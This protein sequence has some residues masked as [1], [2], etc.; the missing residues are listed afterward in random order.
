M[1]LN[2]LFFKI[3]ALLTFSIFL[4]ENSFSAGTNGKIN[5]PMIVII[6]PG[7]G[8]K[9]PG[10]VNKGI[11]EKD[12]VLG[13]GLKLG[14]YINETYPDVKVIYTRSTDVFVPLIE[15]SRIANKNKADLFISLHANYCGTPSLR[16]TE[17]FVLGLHRSKENLDIAKKENSVILMEENYSTTYEGFDP[18]SSESYI[19]F[20]L[21]QDNYLDQSLSFADDIQRQF[22]MRVDGSNRGVKQAGFLVLRQSSMPSVLVETGFISNLAEAKQLM[23]DDGQRTIALSILEAFKKFKTRNSGSGASSRALAAETSKPDTSVNKALA[24][25]EEAKKEP[26]VSKSEDTKPATEPEKQALKVEEKQEPEV[27]KEISQPEPV[28]EKSKQIETPTNAEPSNINQ[29]ATGTDIY[30][31]VQIGANTTPVEPVSAN[32]KGLKDI[33]RDKTD[34]YYRYYVG[35]ESSMESIMPLLEKIKQKFPQAFIVCFTDGKRTI[36]N[37]EVK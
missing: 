8:G 1:N 30:F 33:R 11:Q 18:N 35:K 21:V 10:A 36:I 14:K 9:D 12:V 20:E 31:S 15:R 26:V 29:A 24:E 28:V 5:K 16:G 17:T 25:K 34:K 7:H 4:T 22:K 19:M 2:L 32:F 27:K 3:T 37:T 13:I 23:S 6:D